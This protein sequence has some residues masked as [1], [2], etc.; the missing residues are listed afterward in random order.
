VKLVQYREVIPRQ[1]KI[2]S[3]DSVKQM[4]VVFKMVDD[5][6]TL[7]AASVRESGEYDF[8]FGGDRNYSSV[9]GE[10]YVKRFELTFDNLYME[11]ERDWFSGEEVQQIREKSMTKAELA[12]LEA[13]K[14]RSSGIDGEGEEEK[15]SY[16]VGLGQ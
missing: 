15:V 9:P 4:C 6:A 1:E 13:S 5:E 10:T 2:D 8:Y 11:M 7:V 3:F 14:E 16:M 12:A